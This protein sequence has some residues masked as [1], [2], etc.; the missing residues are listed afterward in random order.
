MK[1]T[2]Y[3]NSLGAGEGARVCLM[4]AIAKT[5]KGPGSTWQLEKALVD[6]GADRSG[7]PEESVPL[8]E[9]S[10]GKIRKT[11]RLVLTGAGLT[12]MTILEDLVVCVGPGKGRK[13]GVSG[14]CCTKTSLLVVPQL[15]ASMLI[16]RDL[17]MPCR[18]KIDFGKRSLC[19]GK[20]KSKC[21]T[22]EGRV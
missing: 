18:A 15:Q 1:L 17:L 4:V 10:I 9:K 6:T 12:R 20:T 3:K 21:V 7:I 2:C 19:F 22:L 16:G 8:L 14:G 5:K 13:S 11:T